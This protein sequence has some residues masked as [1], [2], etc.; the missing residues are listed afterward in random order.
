LTSQG[1]AFADLSAEAFLHYAVETRANHFGR[2][3]ELYVGHLALEGALPERPLPAG[4]PGDAARCAA[5]TGDDP[6][7]TRRKARHRQ[8]AARQMVTAYLTRRS[9]DID[10]TTLRQLA[11]DSNFWAEIERINPEPNDL[12]LSAD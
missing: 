12:A 4:C 11:T 10:Y 9:H 5:G 7:R 3:Y 8:P 2:G 1:I 6:G